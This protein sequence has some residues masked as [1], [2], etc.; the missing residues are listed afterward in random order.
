MGREL[1]EQS[2]RK[3]A[4]GLLVQAEWQRL[5]G[6]EISRRAERAR[7]E[8]WRVALWRKRRMEEDRDPAASQ[9]PGEGGVGGGLE[10]GGL[11]QRGQRDEH[12]HGLPHHP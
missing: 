10:D 8:G 1:E 7:V 5:G 12:A 3:E 9:K 6:G 2:R 4:F 11:P